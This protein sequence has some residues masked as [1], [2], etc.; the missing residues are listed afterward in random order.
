MRCSPTSRKC[1]PNVEFDLQSM[2]SDNLKTTMRARAASGDMPDIVTWMK[3]IEPEY[4]MDLTGQ[5]FL[6]NLNADTVA[7]ANAI[8]DEGIYAMPIDNGYIALYYNKGRAGCQQRRAAHHAGRVPHRVR[9]AGGQWRY[10][11][12]DRLP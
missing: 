3:E 11:L 4:L 6:D 5:A 10:A 8:Y 12:C 2:S 7:G 1:T 9:N